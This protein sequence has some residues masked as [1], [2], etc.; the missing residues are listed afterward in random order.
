MGPP[1]TYTYYIPK[2]THYFRAYWLLY[3]PSHS[4]FVTLDYAH[5]VTWLVLNYSTT[6]K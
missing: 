6:Q 3:V 2:P 1:Q 4:A 5:R